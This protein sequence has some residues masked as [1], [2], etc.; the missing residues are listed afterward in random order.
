MLIQGIIIVPNSDTPIDRLRRNIKFLLGF[1]ANTIIGEKGAVV[2]FNGQ[3]KF[4]REIQGIDEYRISLEKLFF[5]CGVP[6]YVGDSATWIREDK[7]F[8]PNSQLLIID[9]LRQQSIGLYLKCSDKK[10]LTYTNLD[11]CE[12]GLKMISTMELPNGLEPLDFNPNYGIAIA[13]AT[14]VEKAD[15][16]R[17]IKEFFDQARY[18][19]V[20]DQMADF[21]DDTNV[22]QCAVG[23]AEKKYKDV[24]TFVASK[25][26]TEGL[27]ECLQWIV[28]Q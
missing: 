9:A 24:A 10:G 18:Y 16:Y 14:G 17:L 13:N 21:I 3:C 25:H 11:W 19:M 12:K 28:S 5:E 23:N 4:P 26:I 6:V 7:I 22:V 2:S 8:I 1:H 20:G 15:G 27:E